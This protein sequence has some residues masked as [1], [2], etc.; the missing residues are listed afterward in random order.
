MY[1]FNELFDRLN[2]P[3][4]K[5]NFIKAKLNEK[6]SYKPKLGIFGKTGEW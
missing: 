2:I 5:R 4:E 6:L 3:T 1:D